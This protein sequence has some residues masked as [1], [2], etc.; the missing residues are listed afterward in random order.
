[1]LA[2]LVGFAGGDPSEPL[3]NII[4]FNT[5]NGPV[6]QAQDFLKTLYFRSI[7]GRVTWREAATVLRC[8]IESLTLPRRQG[9][10]DRYASV[11]DDPAEAW[12]LSHDSVLDP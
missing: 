11:G 9:G 8:N 5:V 2:E 4:S 1:M 10:H 7:T 6:T 3:S 12:N